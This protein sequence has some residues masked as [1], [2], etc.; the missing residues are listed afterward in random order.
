MA[1]CPP[2]DLA[3]AIHLVVVVIPLAAEEAIHSVGA[4]REVAD[5][6]KIFSIRHGKWPC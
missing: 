4:G 3:V 1:E 5:T 6:V 2:H